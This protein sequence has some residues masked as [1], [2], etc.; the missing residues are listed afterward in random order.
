VSAKFSFLVFRRK[1]IDEMIW[2][3]EQRGITRIHGKEERKFR[4][5]DAVKEISYKTE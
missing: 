5:V 2:Q 3:G 1:I 4:T